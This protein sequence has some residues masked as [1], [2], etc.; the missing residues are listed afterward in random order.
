MYKFIFPKIKYQG[1]N[2]NPGSQQGIDAPTKIDKIAAYHRYPTSV[3]KLLRSPRELS[4]FVHARFGLLN[5]YGR[6]LLWEG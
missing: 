5:I 6:K 4:D 3:T 1:S 2:A